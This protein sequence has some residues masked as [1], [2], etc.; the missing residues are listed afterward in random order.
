[1]KITVLGTRGIPNIQGGVETHCEYLYPRIA[2]TGH[3]V[4]LIRRK[5]YCNNDRIVEYKGISLV[6]LNTPKKKSFEAIIHTFRAIRKAK[7]LKTDI[8]HI[9]AIGPA[10]LT[11]FAR[12]LG[13]KVVF[14]H[15]GADYDRDK[16]G[17]AAKIMLK[18]GERFGCMFANEVIV[19]SNV[20]DNSIK[21]KYNRNDANLIYNGVPTPTIISSINYLK[22]L[23][24]DS[25]K[26]VFAMGRFVPE[27]NF[28]HL[29][30]AFV[31]LKQEGYKLVIAGDADFEDDY[32]KGLKELA[33][34]NNVILTGFIKGD[35]LYELL[36]H[37]KVFV[38]PSSHEGL[39]IALLEAMSYQLPIVVSDIPANLEVGLE[40]SCYFHVGNEKELAEKI[41]VV[42]NNSEVNRINY[43]MEPYHWD[44]IA[45]Q[46][47]TIYK[48]L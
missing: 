44:R 19:I 24:V 37:A 5:S 23:G 35:K 6:D 41:N 10:L 1:M 29:I 27:K 43:N 26:Y 13:M 45:E 4:I 21:E 3:E 30:G 7:K 42:L 16:W 14:T 22:E 34:E 31:S 33:I 8:V 2:A 48:K 46:T 40:P 47:M 38:L 12:I 32:S 11:P 9:H 39:P 25:Q 28:H 17:K 36:T 15:H 18:L 20:I